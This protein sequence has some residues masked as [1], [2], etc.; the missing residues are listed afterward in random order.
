MKTC[1]TCLNYRVKENVSSISG[2]T[3][4]HDYCALDP[5]KTC[6]YCVLACAEYNPDIDYIKFMGYDK[7]TT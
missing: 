4:V 7:E 2:V 3:T 1:G 6:G 5:C